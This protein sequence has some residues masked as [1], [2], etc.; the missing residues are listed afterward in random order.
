MSPLSDADTIPDV[1]LVHGNSAQIN[2]LIIAVAFMTG[3]PLQGEFIGR[4]TCV[5]LVYK[6]MR[7]RN[8]QVAIPGAGERALALVGDDEL[9]F[10]VPKE[11]FEELTE[12]LEKSQKAGG[13]RYPTLFPALLQ[14]PPYH[15]GHEAVFKELGLK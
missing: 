2:R 12:G 11:K 5:N 14:A 10:A 7:D 15:P 1:V 9:I 13:C 8:Y 3:E 4:G 6:S